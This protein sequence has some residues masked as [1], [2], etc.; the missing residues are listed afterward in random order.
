MKTFTKM[1]EI[2]PEDE[3]IIDQAELSIQTYEGIDKDS[4]LKFA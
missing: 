1:L 4:I 3:R 2:N